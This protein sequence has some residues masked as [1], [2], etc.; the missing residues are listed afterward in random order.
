[1]KY[2]E[3]FCTGGWPLFPSIYLYT[4]TCMYTHMHVHMYQF[5]FMD[6]YTL[7]YNPTPLH[8]VAQIVTA[9]AVGAFQLF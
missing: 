7:G 8:C 5:G 4:H 6:I 9:L 2:L 3:F 1:M